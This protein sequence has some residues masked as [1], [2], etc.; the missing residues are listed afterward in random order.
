MKKKGKYK[1]ENLTTGFVK[2]ELVLY[3]QAL[4]AVCSDY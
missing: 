4:F 3:T 2:S 1:S